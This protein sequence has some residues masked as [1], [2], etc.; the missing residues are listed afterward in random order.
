[1]KGKKAVIIVI[2]TILVACI[3]FARPVTLKLS[4][5]LSKSVK[6]NANILI[7]EGWLPFEDLPFAVDE[8]NTGYYDVI[9]TTGLKATPEYYNVN[10][11]G[12]LIFY[13]AR[14]LKASG[15]VNTVEVKAS[16]EP[17]G[18]NKPHFNLW[19]NDSVVADFMAANRR[20]T[21]ITRWNGTRVDSVMIQFDND[22]VGDF[23]DRNLYVSKIILNHKT[24]IPF[25]NNSVYDI[26][27]L[28]SRI[29][30]NMNSNAGI[31]RKRLIALGIDSSKIIDVAGNRSRINRTL[32]S[33]VAA[34]DLLSR[35]KLNV[36][37]I[38][39]IS[40][41]PHSRRTWMTFDKVIDRDIP[42]GIVALPYGN[43]MKK[44]EVHYLRIYREL[45]AYLWY[46]IVLVFY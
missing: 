24:I 40:S 20:K 17:G 31:T 27:A 6:V 30:N 12:Y 3:V 13:T 15:P 22:L 14:Y 39:I 25:L 37:G 10:T 11:D 7:V 19:I 18:S 33:A 34:R 43:I 1:M 8:F 32:T 41:G 35:K 9:L 23:G 36:K 16:G 21:Y 2:L 46:R 42:F 4:E 28:K 29:I 26:P 5:F 44:D 38:N 45:V